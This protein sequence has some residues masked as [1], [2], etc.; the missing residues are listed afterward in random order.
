LGEESKEQCSGARKKNYFIKG[1]EKKEGKGP[2]EKKW[3]FLG[4]GEGEEK[5]FWRVQTS[6]SSTQGDRPDFLG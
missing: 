5:L 4:E 1:K 6:Q 3:C 2:V